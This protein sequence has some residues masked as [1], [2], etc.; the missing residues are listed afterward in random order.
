MNDHGVIHASRAP[1]ALIHWGAI[2]PAE[3]PFAW[4]RA[5]STHCAWL[6]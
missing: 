4:F 3:H 1:K 2:P 5:R 6:L